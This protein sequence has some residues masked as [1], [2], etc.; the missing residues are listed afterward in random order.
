[1]EAIE[2]IHRQKEESRQTQYQCIVTNK[3]EKITGE[4]K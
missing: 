1:M 4:T 2:I 3:K